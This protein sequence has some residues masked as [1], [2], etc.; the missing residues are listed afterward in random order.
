VPPSDRAGLAATPGVTDLS[1]YLTDF[2]ETA[3]AVESLDLVVTVDTSVAHLAGGLG[4]PVWGL[5]PSGS[6]W[7]WVLG[8]EDRPWYPTMRLFRQSGN[9]GW[10]GVVSR[11]GAELRAVSGGARERLLPPGGMVR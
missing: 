6:G 9:E 4:E 2:V 1:S 11:V 10:G 5:L 7:R 8:R 3:G